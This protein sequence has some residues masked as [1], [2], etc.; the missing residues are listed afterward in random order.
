MLK[1]GSKSPIDP[2]SQHHHRPRHPNHHR[3]FL[4][5]FHPQR[6]HQ[7]T[8]LYTFDLNYTIF[9]PFFRYQKGYSSRRRGQSY[10]HTHTSP[11]ATTRV[12]LK[13]L[14]QRRG[15]CFSGA[16]SCCGFDVR[17]LINLPFALIFRCRARVI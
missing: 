11:S 7:H 2:H 4:P 3:S 16:C 17:F 1:L 9:S 15:F 8:P 12:A 14:H 13:F 6:R 5:P 10:N